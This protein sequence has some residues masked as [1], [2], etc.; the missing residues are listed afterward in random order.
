MD[1]ILKICWWGTF[2]PLHGLDK[3]LQAMKILKEHELQFT[4]LYC[5]DNPHFLHLCR[6]IQLDNLEQHVV[7]RKDLSFPDGSLPST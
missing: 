6:K 3:I 4:A 1:G 2:I 5:V 7:L